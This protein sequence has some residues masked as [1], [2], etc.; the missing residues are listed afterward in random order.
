MAD[1]FFDEENNNTFNQINEQ[2]RK[3]FDAE[4]EIYDK[5]DQQYLQ[6][7]QK[8]QVYLPQQ[9]YEIINTAIANA[10][11]PEDEAYRWASALELSN[12][13][14]I[15]TGEAYQ[16]LEQIIAAKWGE[17]YKY[18]PKT[19]FKA[20]VDSGK[21]GVNTLKQGNLGLQIMAAELSGGENLTELLDKYYAIEKEN[22]GLYDYM[23]RNI[24]IEALKFGA[25]SAPFTGYVAGM[26]ILGSLLAPGVGTAASFTASMANATGLQYMSLRKDGSEIGAATGL[27]LVS[28]GL[29]AVVEVALGN[30]AGALGKNALGNSARKAISE[31]ITSN[32]FKRLN[33]NGTMKSLAGKLAKEYLKENFEEGMEEVV[34]DLI[35][36]GTTALAAELGNY[37]IDG[38]T[39]TEIARSAWENFYGGVLGSLVLGLPTSAIKV[40]S[41]VKEFKKVRDL[42]EEIPS[43]EVF[44]KMTEN[45]PIFNEMDE[46][47]KS[48]WQSEIHKNVQDQVDAELNLKAKE[49]G[50]VIGTEGFEEE[51]TDEETGDTIIEPEY[52]NDETGMLHYQNVVNS[53]EDGVIQGTFAAGDPTKENSNKYAKILYTQDKNTN[54]VTIDEFKVGKIRRDL[55]GEIFDN[56][57]RTFPGMNIEWNAKGKVAQEWKAEFEEAN[58]QGQKQ[59]LNYYASSDD[60][61]DIEKRK[62]VVKSIKQAYK[63]VGKTLTNK[64][65]AADVV[66]LESLYRRLREQQDFK[67]RGINTFNDYINYTFGNQM[68][69]DASVATERAQEQFAS[70]LKKGGKVIVQGAAKART[71]QELDRNIKSIIYVTENGD[72]STFSHEIAHIA[73]KQLTGDL[74]KQVEASMGVENG[75][76]TEEKEEKFAFGF[77]QFLREGKAENEELKSFYEK[78]AQFLVDVFNK[79]KNVIE[80]TPDI[81][82]TYNEL[83]SK[84]DNSVLAAASNAVKEEAITSK[85]AELAR[86]RKENAMQQEEIKQQQ[87]EEANL[88]E[89]ESE[90]TLDEDNNVV[91]DNKTVESEENKELETTLEETN[92]NVEEQFNTAEVLNDP[93]SSLQE[94][95]EVANEAAASAYSEKEN[96]DNDE[97]VWQ[98]WY[99]T[100]EE[101]AK[102][103]EDAKNFISEYYDEKEAARILKNMKDLQFDENNEETGWYNMAVE[104]AL[105]Q[106]DLR[107]LMDGKD[108]AENSWILAESKNHKTNSVYDMLKEIAKE[109]DPERRKQKAKK[110]IEKYFDK[111]GMI[112]NA[113]KAEKAVNASI[114][115]CDPSKGCAKFCYVVANA[116]KYKEFNSSVKSELVNWYVTN[117]PVEAAERTAYEY[118]KY[119][120]DGYALR[121]FDKGDLTEKWLPYVEALNNTH[122]LRTQ[123]FTKRGE[124]AMKLN[125]TANNLL[126]SIDTTNKELADKYPLLRLSIVYGGK[127][128]LD[129]VKKYKD[130]V[131]VLLAVKENNK[132]LPTA[133]VNEARE[134]LVEKKV[135]CPVDEGKV[136]SNTWK[137]LDCQNA[138]IGCWTGDKTKAGMKDLLHKSD[139]EIIK[140]VEQQGVY[141]REANYKYIEKHNLHGPALQEYIDSVA[142]MAKELATL[143]SQCDAGRIRE[144]FYGTDGST[145]TGHDGLHP[146]VRLDNGKINYQIIGLKGA[147]ALDDYEEVTK[148]IDNKNIAEQMEADGKDAKAIRMATGWEKGVDGQWRYEIKDFSIKD[149]DQVYKNFINYNGKHAIQLGQLLDGEGLFAAYPML[150]NMTLMFENIKEERGRN[151]AGYYTEVN[152]FPAIVVDNEYYEALSEDNVLWEEDDE[153]GEVTTEDLRTTTNLRSTL[154]HEIQHAIQSIEGFARGGTGE[155]ARKLLKE[156][157][158]NKNNVTFKNEIAYDQIENIVGKRAAV[159]Y[160]LNTYRYNDLEKFRKSGAYL[161]YGPFVLPK[162][163]T[164]RKEALELAYE[165]WNY[166]QRVVVNELTNSWD[167]ME[168]QDMTESELDKKYKELTRELN[169]LY[170]KCLKTMKQVQ[171]EFQSCIQIWISC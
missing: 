121:L 5:K 165:K 96:T 105:I 128:D 31:K 170:E 84:A 34:Q 122:K 104:S 137:C 8:Y 37:D 158:K 12:Q 66:I 101:Y 78:I 53:E 127:Q 147:T 6:D 108:F 150:K 83:L 9:Q 56:F 10:E 69:G 130:R 32:V 36:K 140:A 16:N 112:G 142:D 14:G 47:E 81:E 50:E 52:R 55:R 166:A 87:Q 35:E 72:F 51:V 4:N 30:V 45:S 100:D 63:T 132:H 123:I 157:I 106:R 21:L 40:R 107:D 71:L 154:I 61:A 64:Q 67:D 114:L 27:S 62:E 129:T 22:E 57:A 125:P 68:F 94:K 117:Y 82:N 3:A 59:G 38:V 144:G 97:V 93:V 126:L 75:V 25:Q 90:V 65:L 80:M 133:V 23:D 46:E 24:V 33:Y 159:S 74:L 42:A 160:Y 149:L 134:E 116:S 18:T 171:R 153:T 152:G 98:H 148:R 26:G 85:Y 73:R 110:R 163:E 76:W 2:S 143:Q 7:L 162:E 156:Q 113:G 155:Y 103:Q 54:T 28:G 44:K 135:V 119:Q 49:Y 48:K 139:S 29:E 39:A 19:A 99:E 131:G 88:E 79:L 89:A 86:Q 118:E 136:S 167:R 17:E 145:S 115:N 102:A 141:L 95:T 92:L 60:I 168:Y 161:E 58:P 70:E 41:E 111:W 164:A 43:T 1:I 138:C 11:I 151:Y 15:D 146:D 109:K 77:E 20:I 169:S 120:D 13:Y 124:L 91:E